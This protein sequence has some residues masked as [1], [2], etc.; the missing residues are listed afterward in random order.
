MCVKLPY[1]D[2][3]PDPYPS[4]PINIYTCEVTIAPR[5]CGGKKKK[6]TNFSISQSDLNYEK[7][8]KYK[9]LI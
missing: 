5:V 8:K 7:P 9:I 6:N 2:L 4:N 1:R 3:N